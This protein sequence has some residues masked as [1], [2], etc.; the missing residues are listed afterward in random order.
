MNQ[1]TLKNDNEPTELN[2]KSSTTDDAKKRKIPL[3]AN[4]MNNFFELYRFFQCF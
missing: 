3:V 1:F 4:T 2:R